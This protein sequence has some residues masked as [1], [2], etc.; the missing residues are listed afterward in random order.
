MGKADVD[1]GL[2]PVGSRFLGVGIGL[3]AFVV[4]VFLPLLI[5][6]TFYVMAN[7]YAMVKG[8]SFSSQT[9]NDDVLLTLLVLSAALF[10]VLLSVLISLLGRAFSPKRRT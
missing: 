5:P 2:G 7:V 1:A 4:F 9:A 6:V 8:T 10:P 3:A